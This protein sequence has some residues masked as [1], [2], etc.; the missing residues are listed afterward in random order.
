MRKA[1]ARS[2]LAVK[3][4]RF[5]HSM[6]F[7]L[8]LW[9]LAVLALALVVFGVTI[10]SIEERSLSGA[11]DAELGTFAEPVSKF[12]YT[13]N[14]QF[15]LPPQFENVVQQLPSLNLSDPTFSQLQNFPGIKSLLS[16]QFFVMLVDA[17]GKVT[18][19]IGALSPGDVSRLKTL[20]VQAQDKSEATNTSLE[21]EA[22]ADPTLNQ[23]NNNYRIEL[24]PV[25]EASTGKVNGT[26]VLGLW[27][28][29]AATLQNLLWTLVLAGVATLVLTAGGGYWLASRAIRPVN[30][31]TRIARS[32]TE[33]DLSR[34]INLKNRDEI[35]ELAAT[36]DGMLERLENA[37]ERQRQFTADASHELRTPLTIINLEVDRIAK[38]PRNIAEYERAISIIQTE[39]EYMT[40]LVTDLLTLARADSGRIIFKPEPLDLSDLALEVVERLAPL[41][42]QNEIELTTGDL[43]EIEINGDRLYLTRMLANLVENGIK[44]TAGKGNLVEVETGIGGLNENSPDKGKWAWIRVRDNGPGIAPQHLPYL[45]DRFYQADKARGAGAKSSEPSLGQPEDKLRGSGL[46][47]SIVRWVAELHGGKVRVESEEGQGTTFEVWLPWPN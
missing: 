39:N 26:L 33:T 43:P 19:Q 36:F 21:L 5:I 34:R 35:G 15:Q 3:L 6:R 13:Q 27:W 1:E 24:Y 46:G 37:F 8:S 42:R 25:R 16:G 47:L 11:I 17:Q 31:I 9:Y 14:G 20:A 45:F 22:R 2:G 38:Q 23:K 10:Y 4:G 32:I 7:R 40:R 30:R 29:G 12:I 18:Q 41:A 28:E 44:Y